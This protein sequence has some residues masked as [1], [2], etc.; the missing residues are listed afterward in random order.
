[1][2]EF[3]KK[4]VAILR[5]VPVFPQHDCKVA[6]YKGLVILFDDVLWGRQ[7][8][9]DA[10]EESVFLGSTLPLHGSVPG[11]QVPQFKD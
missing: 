6:Y 8:V 4:A 11:I 10:N 5:T 9:H 7:E 2:D 3:L 1:M